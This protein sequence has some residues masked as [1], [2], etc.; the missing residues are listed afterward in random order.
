MSNNP[1]S[2]GQEMKARIAELEAAL[3]NSVNAE[4]HN[5][6]V[7]E[8]EAEIERMRQVVEAAIDKKRADAELRLAYDERRTF[9]DEL[10]D[11]RLAEAAL[12]KAT[13]DYEATKP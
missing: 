5:Q 8:L 3:A 7:A 9:H 2:Y 1:M 4:W 6:K 13:I 12:V 11:A 10:T